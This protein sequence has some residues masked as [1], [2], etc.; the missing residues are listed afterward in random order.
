MVAQS[1]VVIW[2]GWREE[3]IFKMY[4]E[5]NTNSILGMRGRGY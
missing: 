1:C 5:V 3:N 4:S 2:K